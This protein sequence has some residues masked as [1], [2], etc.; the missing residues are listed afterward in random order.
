MK[1]MQMIRAALA[2]AAIAASAASPAVAERVDCS[3]NYREFWELMQRYGSA[4]PSTEDLV[5]TQ[6]MG[7]RAYDA[8]QAG[9]ESNFSNFW[10]NMRT[11]GN[12]QDD[13]QRF[14]AEIQRNGAARR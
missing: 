5:S 9:D 14:W 7:L 10:E 2:A 1:T 6:R 4:K 11:Y 3:A 8:C 12:S 13:A